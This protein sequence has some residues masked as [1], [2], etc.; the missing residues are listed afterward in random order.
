[1]TFMEGVS[2]SALCNFYKNFHYGSVFRSE[3]F[4]LSGFLR[5]GKFLV[6][7]KSKEREKKKDV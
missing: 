1:M 6:L 4:A 5:H 3:H 2:C 7:L